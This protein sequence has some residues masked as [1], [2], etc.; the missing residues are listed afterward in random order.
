MY[1]EW[2]PIFVQPGPTHTE[3]RKLLRKV[4]GPQTVHEY[5]RA[6]Q[7]SISDLIKVLL[8]SEGDPFLPVS[9]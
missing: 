1:H 2:T 6:I 4:I 9:Q 8:T 5:D 7:A 3:Q